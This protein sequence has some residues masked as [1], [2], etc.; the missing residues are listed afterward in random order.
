MA[1]I[2]R[3]HVILSGAMAAA[4][5]LVPPVRLFATAA[6]PR[7]KVSFAVPPGAC[8]THVHIFGDPQ[9]YPF[10]PAR[11]YTPE[12]ASVAE[13]RSSLAALHLDRVV[14]VHPSVYGTDNRCTLDA[15]RELGSRAR[16]IAVIDA[17]T[18]DKEL[19]EM[20]RIGVRGLRI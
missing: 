9:K 8:D 14:I 7:T 10:T 19:D 11:A 18:P 15:L 16:A 4:A 17:N 3:R 6:Q 5:G 20:A 12:Q 13:L 1:T 2:S